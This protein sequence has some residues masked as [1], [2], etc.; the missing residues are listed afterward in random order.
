M[1][2]TAVLDII[3]S[4]AWNGGTE[5]DNSIYENRGMFFKGNIPVNGRTIEER[6]GVRTR[7]VAPADERIGLVALQDLLE[8]STIDPRRIK[9]IIGATNVGDDKYEH[10]PL[11]THPFKLLAD[12]CPEAVALDLYAGCP[13]FNVSVELAFMLSLNNRLQKDDITVIIGA[14]NIHRSKAFQPTDQRRCD[15]PLFT[16]LFEYNR[17]SDTGTQR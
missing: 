9:L 14:E 7:M 11:V 17:R 1:S 5:V 15:L 2:R 3:A 8:T 13:G 10:G 16:G 12:L 4:G 6:I